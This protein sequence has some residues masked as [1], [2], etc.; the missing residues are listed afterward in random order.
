M[1][2]AMGKISAFYISG[3]NKTFHKA[4]V[5]Q[6]GNKMILSSPKV[7]KPVAVRYNWSNNAN[8]TLYNKEGLPAL[9]FR[10]DNW[11]EVFYAE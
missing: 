11:D 3:E 10:T 4:N 6:E 5:K 7:S 9:P 8:G 2:L 1:V